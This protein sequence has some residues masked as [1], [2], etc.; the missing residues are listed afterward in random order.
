MCGRVLSS[1]WICDVKIHIMCVKTLN[2]MIDQFMQIHKSD[3][4]NKIEMEDN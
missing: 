1:R 2:E 4:V 3:Q